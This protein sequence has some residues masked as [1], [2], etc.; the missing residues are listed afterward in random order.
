MARL[1]RLYIG[2]N[3]KMF[4]TAKQTVEYLEALDSHTRDLRKE[5]IT[6]F[7]L[8]SYTSLHAANY[9]LADSHILLGAQ[10]IGFEARGEF[11]G[12][13]SPLML[14]EAGAGIVMCGHSERR[15][16]FGETDEDQMRKVRCAISNGMTALL[17][18]GETRLQKDQGIGPETLETQ[19]KIA[20]SGL[21][22]ADADRLLIAYEPVWAIGGGGEPA[23][24]DYAE[25]MHLVIRRTL[26]NIFGKETGG[27]IPILYG[28]SVNIDNAVSFVDMPHINGIYMGRS[29][30]DAANFERII[31]VAELAHFAKRKRS[32]RP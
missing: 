28:G 4:M 24:P 32:V 1:D 13:I 12:E 5:D 10:N 22:E 6:I 21:S 9:V 7:V 30:L 23:S 31:R 26:N 27:D 20:L 11:T 25:T 3:T 16:I 18:V 8:P 29:S 15:H 19:L 17:C 2:A 14:I